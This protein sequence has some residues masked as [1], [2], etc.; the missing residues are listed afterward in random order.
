MSSNPI[1]IVTPAD[2]AEATKL[3]KAFSKQ[4]LF[5]QIVD[6][7]LVGGSLDDGEPAK[8]TKPT[9]GKLPPCTITALKEI[10]TR[11]KEE[12]G[13]D[14]LKNLF[15]VHDCKRLGDLDEKEYST[16]YAEAEQL[17]NPG[18]DEEEEMDPFDLLDDD[19]EE[20]DDLFGM[21]D[22]DEDADLDD[23]LDADAPSLDEVKKT[24]S[25][26]S[27]RHGLDKQRE[28]LGKFGINTTRSLGKASAEQL[29]KIQALFVKGLK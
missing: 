1:I 20:D 3:I 25:K 14:V 26:Y 19:E 7:P 11:V 13:S 6:L 21:D 23:D 12:L 16:V 27:D 2:K 22:E 8:D 29:T 17:L 4:K 15:V 5:A 24:A 9:K 28:I 10:L 18:A